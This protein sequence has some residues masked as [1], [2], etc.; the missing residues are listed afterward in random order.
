MV[1]RFRS[2]CRGPS[3]RRTGTTLQLTRSPLLPLCTLLECLHCSSH[4]RT[5]HPPRG[6]SPSTAYTSHRYCTYTWHSQKCPH[7]ERH[8]T[9]IGLHCSRILREDPPG[10]TAPL[11]ASI[12]PAF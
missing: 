2:C 3:C 6:A 10:S 5:S 1:C 12:R 7:L 8:R 4:C 11:F 9:D